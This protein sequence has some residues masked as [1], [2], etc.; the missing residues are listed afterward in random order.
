M[1]RPMP[2]KLP[3]GSAVSGTHGRV[4]AQIAYEGADEFSAFSLDPRRKVQLKQKR[5]LVPD[6]TEAARVDELKRVNDQ[7]VASFFRKIFAR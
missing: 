6:F 4:R 2:V 3:T 1:R 7:S 5:A